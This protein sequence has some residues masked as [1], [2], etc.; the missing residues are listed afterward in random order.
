MADSRFEL[1][2]QQTA[3]VQDSHEAEKWSL[4]QDGAFIDPMTFNVKI[5]LLYL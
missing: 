2:W 3:L 1:C 4:Y 5:V